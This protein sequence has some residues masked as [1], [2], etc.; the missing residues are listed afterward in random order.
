MPGCFG[1]SCVGPQVGEGRG[2]RGV[3]WKGRSLRLVFR[4]ALPGTSSTAK[5]QITMEPKVKDDELM[6][7]S[8]QRRLLLQAI[9]SATLLSGLGLGG[10]SVAQE[11]RPTLAQDGVL[12]VV[13]IG[14]GLS[15][16]TS[17]RDLLSAGCESFMVLEARNRV[18]GRTYNHDWATASSPK[19][20]ASGS[21]RA[22]PP[23]P[24]WPVSWTSEPSPPITRASPSTW[25]GMPR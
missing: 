5:Q 3:A 2:C 6:T 16:L 24:I 23:S 7:P 19:P 18:G 4:R 1:H 22:R 8:R 21:V 14:A 20:A 12:D 10:S 13:V 11:Q 25:R 9:G 17:A 15:G